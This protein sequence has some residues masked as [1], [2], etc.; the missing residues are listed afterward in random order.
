MKLARSDAR[1]ATT[2]AIS[3]GCAARPMGAPFDGAGAGGGLLPDQHC[4]TV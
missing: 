2:S 1:K 4:I 3:S